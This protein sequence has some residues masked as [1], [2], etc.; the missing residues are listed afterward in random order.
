M[1]LIYKNSK[2]PKDVFLCRLTNFFMDYDSF[3]LIL[4]DF[5]INGLEECPLLNRV[6]SNY[7]SM[8]EFPTH[9]DGAMLDHVYV[10]KDLLDSF[11][12]KVIRKCINIS[13]HDGL[14][15]NISL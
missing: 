9:I 5:N 15:V 6:L 3:D 10:H 8:L 2:I 14:K 4:G 11:R 12:F 13:D 7:K 1:L